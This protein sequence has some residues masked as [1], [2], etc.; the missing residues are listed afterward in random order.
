MQTNKN[1]IRINSILAIE[2][3]EDFSGTIM[4]RLVNMENFS[5]SS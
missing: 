1:L 3:V 2:K 5:F 4:R